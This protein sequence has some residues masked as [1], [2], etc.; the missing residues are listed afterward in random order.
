[1]HVL[2]RIVSLIRDMGEE[3]GLRSDAL[4]SEHL[5]SSG[6]SASVPSGAILTSTIFCLLWRH[7][8]GGS[9]LWFRVDINA[10]G[11]CLSP[12]SRAWNLYHALSK[13]RGVHL[14][15]GELW[16]GWDYKAGM[17]YG[18]FRNFTNRSVFIIFFRSPPCLF[19]MQSMC[20]EIDENAVNQLIALD[21]LEQHAREYVLRKGRCVYCGVDVVHNRLGFATLEWDHLLPC[22]L[23]PDLVND[24]D[25]ILLACQLCNRLKS[26]YDPSNGT[27]DM[28]KNDKSQLIENARSYIAERRVEVDTF[29]RQARRIVLGLEGWPDDVS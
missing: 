22:A 21:F 4:E 10:F 25:N 13:M 9:G 27:Q 23:F 6:L 5:D 1:M 20:E 2:R 8:K 14:R 19:G 29:W 18:R 15:T 28:L 12:E 16:C 11:S 24:E 3:A 17:Y 26:D 7:R